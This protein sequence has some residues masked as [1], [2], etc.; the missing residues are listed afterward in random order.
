MERVTQHELGKNYWVLV[1]FKNSVPNFPTNLGNW[2]NL[3]SKLV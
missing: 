1:V 3:S 2:A